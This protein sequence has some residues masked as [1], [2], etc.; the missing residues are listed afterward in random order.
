MQMTAI[1]KSIAFPEQNLNYSS[2]LLRSL[3]Y[4]EMK[5]F[6]VRRGSAEPGSRVEGIKGE[7]RRGGKKKSPNAGGYK[8]F[9]VEGEWGGTDI[10]AIAGVRGGREELITQ[11]EEKLSSRSTCPP[12]P[13]AT[14]EGPWVLAMGS[15]GFAPEGDPVAMTNL[16]WV[17]GLGRAHT[18]QIVTGKTPR[19][20]AG[21]A[22][23]A[24]LQRGCPGTAGT[25]PCT[26]SAARAGPGARAPSPSAL[27]PVNPS[28]SCWR[29]PGSRIILLHLAA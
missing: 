19:N 12:T 2:Q 18:V 23:N 13:T 15:L 21:G 14:R 25:A 16:S 8:Y 7:K 27:H 1:K 22:G 20:P 24:P 6:L 26:G 10:D 4:I 5:R 28:R 3:S 17:L 11:T 29:R 9:T